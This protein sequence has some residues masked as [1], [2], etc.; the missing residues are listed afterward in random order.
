MV[1]PDADGREVRDTHN[2]SK[3]EMACTTVTVQYASGAPAPGYR[4]TLSFLNGGVTPSASTDRHGRAV[5][6]HSTVGEAKILVQ[7]NERDRV[8]CPGEHCVTLD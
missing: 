7:G 4:V 5:L 6:N 1:A 2:R 3:K 8:H